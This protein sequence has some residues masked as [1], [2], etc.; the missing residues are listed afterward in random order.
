MPSIEGDF[1][2]ANRYRAYPFVDGVVELTGA[3]SSY[4]ITE[5]IVDAHVVFRANNVSDTNSD[6]WYIQKFHPGTGQIQLTNTN[7]DTTNELSCET[8]S[9]VLVGSYRT[10]VYVDTSNDITCTLVVYDEHALASESAW[11]E[12]AGQYELV[13][14]CYERE[15]ERVDSIILGGGTNWVIAGD[16]VKERGKLL[17]GY[18][19]KLEVDAETPFTA[20]RDLAQGESLRQPTRRITISANPGYGLGRIDT[21]ECA[22]D[23]T[24]LTTINNTAGRDGDYQLLG[25]DCYRIM[26]KYDNLTPEEAALKISNDCQAC[27]DCVEFVALLENIRKLK[28]EGLAITRVWD[29]ARTEYQEL[30]DEYNQIIENCNG[31]LPQLY[32]YAY[33]GWLVAVQVQVLNLSNCVVSGGSISVSFT[34]GD[35]V[36]HYVEGSGLIHNSQNPVLQVKPTKV[37]ANTFSMGDN[38]AIDAGGYKLFAF[39]VRMGAS[40]SRVIGE[41]VT[42]EAQVETCDLDPV[43]LTTSVSLLGTSYYE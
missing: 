13:P 22:G 5:Y 29:A 3:Y 9:G 32:A 37:N 17:E 34:D 18:N 35:W 2:A 31:C 12:L 26:R 1:L 30:V 41:P 6:Y 27:C 7:G 14:R 20:V 19:I 38:S 21:G 39:S 25:D 43:D 15:P 8:A 42:I 24:E 40:E 28:N 16:Q 33:T 11:L 10:F 36:P 4:D 23:S